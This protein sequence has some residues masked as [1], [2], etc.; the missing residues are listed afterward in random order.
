MWGHDVK[1]RKELSKRE[2]N[3]LGVTDMEK[4]PWEDKTIPY[5][6]EDCKFLDWTH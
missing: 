2:L 3:R 1:V 4:I 5:T 6:K